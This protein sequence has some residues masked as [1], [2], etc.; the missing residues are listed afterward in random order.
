MRLMQKSLS[1]LRTAAP[2]AFFYNVF[3]LAQYVAS[4]LS[5]V[6]LSAHPPSASALQR[7]IVDAAC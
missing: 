3:L 5:S 1:L 6:S 7:T 4:S 2:V